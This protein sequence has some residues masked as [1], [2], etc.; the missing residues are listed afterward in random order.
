LKVIARKCR[1]ILILAFVR[2]YTI[3]IFPA[4]LK[5]YS[6]LYRPIFSACRIFFGT[7]LFTG[8]TTLPAISIAEPQD[9]FGIVESKPVSEIWLNPGFYSYHFQTDK[10][11]NNSNIGLG[12]EY[13]YSTVSSFTLGVFEN[14]DRETSRYAGLYWQPLRLGAFRA[15]AVFGALDGYQKIQKNGWFLA[16]IPAVSYE[17]KYVGFNLMITPSYKDKLYGAISL[18]LKLRVY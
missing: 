7:I 8:L 12:G 3:K 17:Y 16:A 18:Q 10:D 2:I 9:F 15:G 14:S 6:I 5:K 11:L 13:R 4:M 1:E